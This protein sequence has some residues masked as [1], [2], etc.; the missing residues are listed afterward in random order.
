MVNPLV[1]PD[2]SL[3]AGV[4]CIRVYSTY[5]S[6]LVESIVFVPYGVGALSIGMVSLSPRAGTLLLS[7]FSRACLANM[8]LVFKRVLRSHAHNSSTI[9]RL[10]QGPNGVRPGEA[11]DPIV[12]DLS[13]VRG[14]VVS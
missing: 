1:K 9:L 2:A 10:L 11:V 14:V 4:S 8:P 7:T 5:W 12:A 3:P 13:H 6:I